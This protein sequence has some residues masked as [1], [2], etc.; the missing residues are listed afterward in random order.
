MVAMMA[1]MN[2]S[3]GGGSNCGGLLVNTG[4]IA[5]VMVICSDG[6]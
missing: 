4:V 5:V 6:L 1:M 2:C 3:N